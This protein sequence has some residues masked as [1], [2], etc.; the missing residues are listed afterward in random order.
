MEWTRYVDGYCERMG[1]EYWAEPINAIT[2]LA[3][4]LAALVM[5]RRARGVPLARALCV[6]LGLI[7]IGSYLFHTHAQVWAAMADVLPI[8]GFILLY[9]FAVN[10]A[11]FDVS[12][13][14]ALGL[15]ALF[16]PYAGMMVPVF[17]L[18]PALG[19][20]A[21]YAPVPLLI[22]LY[23][24]FLRRRLPEFARGLAIGAG[25]LVLS[26]AF[27]TLDEPVCEAIPMGT[28]FM[29]HV[30]NGVMLGWMIYIY[31]RLMHQKARNSHA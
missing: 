7:G 24:G 17:S 11:A 12:G 30:L 23:A 21:A 22:F 6:V 5:W 2:N 18:V 27:R 1:P 19:G 8:I 3:F 26:L 10:R 16:I 28:H 13:W 25:L 4:V 15:T 31:V 9:L 14:P 20:S 29:W